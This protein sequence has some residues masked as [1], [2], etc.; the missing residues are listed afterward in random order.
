MMQPLFT[1]LT[2]NLND[3]QAH[4]LESLLQQCSTYIVGF[5]IHKDK[6]GK[7]IYIGTLW[8]S[9]NGKPATKHVQKDTFGEMVADLFEVINHLKL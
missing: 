8:Y 9:I 6:D 2:A 4:K 7:I 1:E 3:A 5:S